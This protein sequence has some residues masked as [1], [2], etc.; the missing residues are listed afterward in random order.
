MLRK[1][2]RQKTTTDNFNLMVDGKE[3]EITATCYKTYNKETRYRVTIDESPV[4]IFRWDDHNNRWISDD[5]ES[6]LDIS[7]RL[8]N[9][10]AEQLG[11]RQEMAA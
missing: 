2:I 6:T 8:E 4:Y 11:Q 7:K 5:D 3:H 1:R 9:A 10:I